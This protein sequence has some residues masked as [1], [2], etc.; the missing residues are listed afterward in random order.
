MRSTSAVLFLLA[1]G[2]APAFAAPSAPAVPVQPPPAEFYVVRGNDF[3]GTLTVVKTDLKHSIAKVT[4]T[5]GNGAVTTSDMV[6]SR[7]SAN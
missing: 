4:L 7:I 3:V 5:G 6:L 1:I 2:V